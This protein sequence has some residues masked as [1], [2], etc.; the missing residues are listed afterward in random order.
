LPQA[1]VTGMSS[2]AEKHCQIPFGAYAQVHVEPNPSN[3]AM[4]SRTVGEISLGPKG[5]IQGTYNFLSLFTG[6]VII[7]RSFTPLPMPKEVIRAVETMNYVTPK[8]EENGILQLAPHTLSN[9]K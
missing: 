6:R 2:D 1:I 4:T 5:N 3:D 7:A 8:E 9:N